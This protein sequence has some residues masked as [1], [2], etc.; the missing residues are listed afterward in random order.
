MNSGEG[1]RQNDICMGQVAGWDEKMHRESKA[2][3]CQ[4]VQAGGKHVNLCSK[5][6]GL[7]ISTQC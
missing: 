2:V 3:I 7:R 6:K 1:E 4:T 5:V